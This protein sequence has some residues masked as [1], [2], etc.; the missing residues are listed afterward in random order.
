MIRSNYQFLSPQLAGLVEEAEEAAELS[1]VESKEGLVVPRL[2]GQMLHSKYYPLKEGSR[3]NFNPPQPNSC[4]IA[5]GF[6][7]GYHLVDYCKRGSLL[8]VPLDYGLLKG[9]LARVELAQHFPEGSLKLV[10]AQEV[11]Q[12]FDY[13]QNSSFY[14]IINNTL[15]KIFS[16]ASREAVE[17]IKAKLGRRLLELNTQRHFGQVWFKNI[18]KSFKRLLA[19]EYSNEALILEGRP[20]VV[21]GAGPSLESNIELLKERRE[22]IYLAA[23]DTAYPVLMR[24]GLEPDFVFSFDANSHS[25]LHLAGLERGRARLFVDICSPLYSSRLATT[26]LFSAHP[27]SLILAEKSGVTINS[28]ALN[29][30]GAIVDFFHRYFPDYPLVTVGI[31]FASQG[32]RGYSR[33]SYLSEYYLTHGDYFE[34]S[35][36]I[37]SRL[38]YRSPFLK[39]EGEW[40]STSLYSSYSE[41]APQEG[42]MTLSGSP[43]TPFRQIM[44]LSQAIAAAKECPSLSLSFNF[45]FFEH[46]APVERLLEKLTVDSSALFSYFL[47]K[48]IRP[49]VSELKELL[50]S[51]K[52]YFS[53]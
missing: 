9:V 25:Y 32:Y 45:S 43:F 11:E 4:C 46:Q 21:A 41:A 18:L 40:K 3:Y 1:F 49:G 37:E 8:A 12:F 23:A 16:A 44:D 39:M 27:L 26:P 14:F 33:G 24:Q 36:S 2:G 51:I 53:S 34:S 7:A 19:G 10:S 48:G 28:A 17:L 30:G 29:I 35:S 5:L 6:G 20:I 31:D 52:D 15:Q 50:D 47:A 22:E 13:F 38:F 42:V